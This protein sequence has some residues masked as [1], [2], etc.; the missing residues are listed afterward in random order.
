VRCGVEHVFNRGT[1]SGLQSSVGLDVLSSMRPVVVTPRLVRN[2]RR[3]LQGMNTLHFLDFLRLVAMGDIDQVSRRVTASS[4]VASE[5]PLPRPA[6]VLAD[7]TNGAEMV[8]NVGDAR[9]HPGD[10]DLV[11]LTG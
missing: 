2:G 4:A 7:L 11:N 1:V 10:L 6:C 5:R 3:L 8:G 9:N